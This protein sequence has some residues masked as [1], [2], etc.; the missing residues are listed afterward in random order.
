MDKC[1]VINLKILKDTIPSQNTVPPQ[2]WKASTDQL[3][4]EELQY[5]ETWSNFHKKKSLP[6]SV[7]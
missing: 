5:S 3:N 7:G 2:K 1:V 4:I 6:S